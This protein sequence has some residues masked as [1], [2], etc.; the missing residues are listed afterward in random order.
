M[1]SWK[2]EAKK[3]ERTA[4]ELYAQGEEDEVLGRVF[5][6]PLPRALADP[7][8]KRTGADEDLRLD[9]ETSFRTLLDLLNGSESRVLE[10]SEDWRE[11]LGA[12][13]VWVN[14]GGRREGIP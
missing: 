11:A 3:A 7:D 12:W 14:P 1:R 2:A 10:V 6:S 5:P 9:F 4:E 8:F 13:G